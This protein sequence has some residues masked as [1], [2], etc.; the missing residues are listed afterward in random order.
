MTIERQVSVDGVWVDCSSSKKYKSSL[1][2]TEQFDS[3]LSTATPREAIRFSARL[4]LPPTICKR[5]I[6]HLTNQILQELR[7]LHVADNL[8]GRPDRSGGLSGGEKRRVSLGTQLVIC[9]KLLFLDEVTSGL[10]SHNAFIVMQTCQH[11]AQSGATVLMTIHQPSSKLFELMD[12]IYLMHSGR[13][14]YSGKASDALEFFKNHGYAKPNHYSPCDWMMEVSQT[15]ETAV[16]ERAGFY[17]ETLWE[18]AADAEQHQNSDV[19]GDDWNDDADDDAV[20]TLFSHS[21]SGHCWAS[22]WTEV[23]EQLNRDMRNLR[24][25]HQAMMFRF[26]MI[27][28]GTALVAITFQGVGKDSLADPVEFQF[29]LGALFFIVLGSLIIL[30]IVMLEFAEVRWL[31]I[32]ELASHHYSIFTCK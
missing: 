17:A 1:A 7:L 4:R 21:S 3:L 13:C 2:Y 31:Y 29:N 18:D 10:D 6:D 24:R 12:H 32:R 22:W 15:T 23:T 28:V 11:V 27:A 5:D 16:L 26:I 14:M 19:L 20:A 8:I 30:Q 25:D 9:P